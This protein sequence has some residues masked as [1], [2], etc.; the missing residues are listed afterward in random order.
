MKKLAIVLAAM[1]CTSCLT[2][3]LLDA[4]LEPARQ[5]RQTEARVEKE[6]Q[7]QEAR[8]ERK[9]EIER[10]AEEKKIAREKEREEIRIE[11]ER[12]LEEAYLALTDFIG[13]HT[14]QAIQAGLP[15]LIIYHNTSTPN[16][17]G[18]VDCHIRFVNASAKRMKY[19]NFTV[20]PYNRV[21]D[22]THS[23]TGGQS[24]VTI[25]I[26]D[27]IQPNKTYY[28][29]WENVW[30]NSTISYMRILAVE[31]IYD[32]N[33]VQVISNKGIIENATLKLDEYTEYIQL[34]DKVKSFWK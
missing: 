29:F 1:I 21:D 24:E 34:D 14:T 12:R 3:S 15:I 18:G 22:I 28:G 33:T 7:E 23:E 26:V 17:A 2:V 30:Y 19:V 27:Y 8:V 10:Q 32:D 5:R 6:K 11:Y 25:R 20:V 9:K 13:K 16:S 4:I 31:V